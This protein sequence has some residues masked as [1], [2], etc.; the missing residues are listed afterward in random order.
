MEPDSVIVENGGNKVIVKLF[1]GQ[2]TTGQGL[3]RRS[4]QEDLTF[5]QYNFR[6]MFPVLRKTE[7]EDEK[8]GNQEDKV[9]I[10][11]GLKSICAL[12]SRGYSHV[13]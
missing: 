11:R 1:R 4:R 7:I 13:S 2:E 8:E 12:F 9:G 10:T 3:S 5:S 6:T